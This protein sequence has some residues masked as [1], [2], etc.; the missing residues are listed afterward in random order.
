MGA[1]GTPVQARMQ[2]RRGGSLRSRVKVGSSLVT[3]KFHF[4]PQK[5]PVRQRPD[6]AE[7]N[8]ILW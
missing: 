5:R 8:T 1:N 2:K 3:R 6:G 4:T 7:V